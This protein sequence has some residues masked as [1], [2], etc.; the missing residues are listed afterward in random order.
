[1]PE[2]TLTL[3]KPV[4][5]AIYL[6]GELFGAIAR[7]NLTKEDIDKIAEICKEQ[8]IPVTKRDLERALAVLEELDVGSFV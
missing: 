4:I 6:I 7:P 2:E 5:L 8:G 1:M 3:P